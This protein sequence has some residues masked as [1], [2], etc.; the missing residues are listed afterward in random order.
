MVTWL[1]VHGDGVGKPSISMRVGDGLAAVD[2]AV[3]ACVLLIVVC[4][5]H[6]PLSHYPSVLTP[7]LH[8]LNQTRMTMKSSLSFLQALWHSGCLLMGPLMCEARSVFEVA[9]MGPH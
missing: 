9:P 5:G 3:S 2:I 6:S 1:C 8:G 7:P 4:L